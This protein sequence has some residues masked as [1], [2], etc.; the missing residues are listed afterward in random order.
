MPPSRHSIAV[1]PEIYLKVLSVVFRIR[2]LKRQHKSVNITVCYDNKKNVVSPHV[3]TLCSPLVKKNENNKKQ[4]KM[5]CLLSRQ[6]NFE[7]NFS[8]SR[9]VT[10]L[11]CGMLL[12]ENRVVKL[13]R[14]QTRPVHH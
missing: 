2:P 12:S 4:F 11:D 13:K 10:T 8:V 9:L 1:A 5:F 3:D 6:Q 7:N 14:K